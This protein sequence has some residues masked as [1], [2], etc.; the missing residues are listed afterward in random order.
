[1]FQYI[2]EHLGGYL[3]LRKI[4]QKSILNDSY[5]G[6]YSHRA[7]SLALSNEGSSFSDV[8]NKMVVANRIMSSNNNA[9][10][11][12]K[13]DVDLVDNFTKDVFS[14]IEGTAGYNIDGIDLA[15]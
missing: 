10:V 7:I 15:D 3:T 13:D 14:T 4:W 12:A 5:Y 11:F 6:D 9:G 8:L 1:M 2:F